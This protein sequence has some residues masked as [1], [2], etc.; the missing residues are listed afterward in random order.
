MTYGRLKFCIVEMSRAV[1]RIKEGIARA[2]VDRLL[3]ENEGLEDSPSA[4]SPAN[5]SKPN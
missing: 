4:K 2:V 1:K 5:K 3:Q